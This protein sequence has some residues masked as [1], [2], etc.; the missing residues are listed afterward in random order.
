MNAL[1]QGATVGRVTQVF[2]RNGEIVPFRRNRIVRA[3]LAAVRTAFDRQSS[4]ISLPL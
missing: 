3:I 4:F 2:N 1:N